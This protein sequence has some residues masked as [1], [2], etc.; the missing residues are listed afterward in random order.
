ML[1]FIGPHIA[2]Q[3]ILVGNKKVWKSG[4]PIALFSFHLY[5]LLDV[6]LAATSLILTFFFVK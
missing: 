6:D 3:D 2:V 4:E 5:H 1:V